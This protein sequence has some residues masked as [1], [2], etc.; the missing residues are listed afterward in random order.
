MQLQ[1][2]TNKYVYDQMQLQEVSHNLQETKCNCRRLQTLLF[3]TSGDLRKS[4]TTCGKPTEE[5]GRL[6][7]LVGNP[8][9]FSGTIW[10]P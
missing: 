1:E 5:Y 6:T 9:Q 4:P 10:Q 8:M 2:V 7:Q 3:Y